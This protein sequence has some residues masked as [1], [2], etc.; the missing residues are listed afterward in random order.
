MPVVS[1][2]LSS[3]AQSSRYTTIGMVSKHEYKKYEEKAY[4]IMAKIL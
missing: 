4:D 2:L 3:L 1:S